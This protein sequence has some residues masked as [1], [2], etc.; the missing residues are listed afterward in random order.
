MPVPWKLW[1]GQVVDLTFPLRR[2]LG[3]TGQSA[4]FLTQL[5]DPEPR[6]AAIKLV[7]SAAHDAEL[8]DQWDHAAALS[9]PICSS[10]FAKVLAR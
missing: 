5:G 10:C 7:V 9:I 1:E 2:Y 3:S 6:A 8:F 4:V